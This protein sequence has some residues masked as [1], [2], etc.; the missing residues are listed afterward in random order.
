MLV[1]LHSVINVNFKG[2]FCEQIL[3]CQTNLL[4]F[5]EYENTNL[6]QPTELA[7]NPMFPLK[8]FKQQ[9]CNVK[10]NF[11]K[12]NKQEQAKERDFPYFE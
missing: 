2:Y 9:E 7:V 11:Y 5:E 6:M 10:E 1:F 12:F 8:N 3:P 4:H